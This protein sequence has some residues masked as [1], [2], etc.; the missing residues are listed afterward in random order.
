M[1][2]AITSSSADG[3]RSSNITL[4]KYGTQIVYSWLPHSTALGAS[5]T[6]VLRVRNASLND[7]GQLNDTTSRN[8]YITSTLQ[9]EK[10]Y[11]EGEITNNNNSMNN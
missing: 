11:N 10:K 6:V 9:D 7:T 3:N 1:S 2:T 5:S 4:N 8:N